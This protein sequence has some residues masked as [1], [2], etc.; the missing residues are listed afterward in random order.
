MACEVHSCLIHSLQVLSVGKSAGRKAELVPHS[1]PRH[2]QV[3]SKG[4]TVTSLSPPH[5]V[6]DTAG[7]EGEGYGESPPFAGSASADSDSLPSVSSM[8]VGLSEVTPTTSGGWGEEPSVAPP[9]ESGDEKPREA[10]PVQSVTQGNDE[11]AVSIISSEWEIRLEPILCEGEEIGV[12]LQQNEAEGLGDR[13]QE[14]GDGAANKSP[15]ARS[16]RLKRAVSIES[17]V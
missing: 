17:V 6:A 4:H 7:M 16:I 13:Q 2:H 3:H 5:H 12:I 14:L 10:I 8:E 11:E 9:T 15:G 1:A